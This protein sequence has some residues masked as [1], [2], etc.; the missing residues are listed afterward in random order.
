MQVTWDLAWHDMIVAICTILLLSPT[1]ISVV[2]YC[3]IKVTNG[4]SV[5]FVDAQVA[6]GG[7]VKLHM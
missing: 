3:N 4:E 1:T 7:A 6:V 5:W 2:V